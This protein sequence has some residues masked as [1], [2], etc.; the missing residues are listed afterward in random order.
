MAYTKNP[1][2][3]DGTAGGTPITAASLQ[4]IEDGIAAAA[5]IADD[6]T[7]AL[8]GK[9]SSSHTHTATGISDST[10]VG[11]SVLTASTATDARTA[12]GLAAVA[13][14]GDAG[15]LSGDPLPDALLPDAATAG[16]KW[17]GTTFVA[18]RVT[19]FTGGSD[20]VPPTGLAAG[21][22]WIREVP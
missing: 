6:A 22:V 16:M 5:Q 18:G 12:L 2:W 15:D 9:A 21:D 17:D 11:R 13:A 1:T 20:A 7:T 19:L 4:H 8:A 14:T 3:V 10:T